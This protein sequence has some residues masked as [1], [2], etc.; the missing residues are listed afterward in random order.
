LTLVG[1]VVGHKPDG[2]SHRFL[3]FDTEI[4]ILRAGI[5]R[6]EVI[7]DRLAG[8]TPRAGCE[9]LPVPHDAPPAF[10]LHLEALTRRKPM[11]PNSPPDADCHDEFDIDIR[12]APRVTIDAHANNENWTEP[13]T[14]CHTCDTQC[15]WCGTVNTC[16]TQCGVCG[17]VHTCETQ[18]GLCPPKK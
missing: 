13:E 4:L 14:S 5:V 16:E 15:G 17:T 18:C 2:S 6:P 1:S 11:S 10:V 12:I 3:N 9:R 7:D 8:H